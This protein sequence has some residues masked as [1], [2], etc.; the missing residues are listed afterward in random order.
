MLVIVG[1]GFLKLPN[2]HMLLKQK[3]S[4]TPQK[5]GSQVF[6]QIANSILKKVKSA[7]LPLFLIGIHSMQG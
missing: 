4:I 1:K 2:L 7:I 6:W 5:L 3:K